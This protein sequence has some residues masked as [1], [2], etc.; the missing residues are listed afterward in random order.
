MS[1]TKNFKTDILLALY[2][3][4]LILANILGIKITTI[5]GIRVSVGIFFV[6]LLFLITD[7]IADVH[8]AQK[9]RRFV[10]LAIGIMLF[11][12]LMVYISIIMPAN[13]TWGNQEAYAEIFGATLRMTLA[14]IIAFVISQTHDVWAFSFLKRKTHGKYLWLR[15]NLSSWT[16]QFIDTT[17]FMFVAFYHVTPKFTVPFI[18]SLIIPYW[19]FKV[20]FAIIDTPLCYVGVK[21]LKK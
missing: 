8:G 10:F 14:S 16:S 12:I 17:I 5:L 15:N 7:I 11:S 20:V 3:A 1:L 13:E 4:S 18:F 2:I 19:L 9:A 21:W 6:P